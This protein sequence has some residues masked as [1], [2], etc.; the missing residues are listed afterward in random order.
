MTS[1][2]TIATILAGSTLFALPL[3]GGCGG[4][5]SG[6]GAASSS[7]SAGPAISASPSTPR[8]KEWA[9]AMAK[10]SAPKPGCFRASHPST[11][12]EEIPCTEPPA[13]PMVPVKGGGRAKPLQVGDGV[14]D[15]TSTVPGHISFAEGSFPATSGF[16]TG[17]ALA[18]GGI[19][20]G[21]SLQMNTNTLSNGAICNQGP[22][23][24]GCTE[25]Q[26]FVYLNGG[27][28]IQYWLINYFA[29]AQAAAAG[30]PNNY[31]SY[32]NGYYQGNTIVHEYDC[33][34]NSQYTAPTPVFGTADLPGLALSAYA[35]GTYDQVTMYT[36]GGGEYLTM[37]AS[38]TSVLNLDQWWTSAEFNVFGPGGGSAA[39]LNYGTTMAVQTVT[40]G[41]GTPTCSAGS[42]TGEIN[43]LT[44][45]PN[46]CCT[47]N[48]GN[49]GIFFTQSN[50]S[51]AAPFA[52]LPTE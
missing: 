37:A 7:E 33:Y 18:G 36:D 9:R 40:D 38:P 44:I 19:L 32:D 10:T 17:G 47:F 13:I 28:F 2:R 25:W 35:G 24:S 52:C 12:W 4:S 15:F 29:T 26:Q 30:C 21:Y 31:G 42:Y 43:N 46:S 51:G 34:W 20:S 23:A 11:T 3:F 39:V 6:S 41:S 5:P 14:G 48:N 22:N 49:A 16:S 45:L 50:V 8:H 1:R 27:I